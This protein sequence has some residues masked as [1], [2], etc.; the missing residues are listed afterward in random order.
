MRE[1]FSR[2]VLA[3]AVVLSMGAMASC[4][5]EDRR[6]VEEVGNEVEKGAEKVGEEVEEGVDELDTDGKDD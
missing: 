5:A 4:D 3:I 2:M 1:R 6:D